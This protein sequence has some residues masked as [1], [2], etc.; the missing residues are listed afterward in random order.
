MTFIEPVNHKE[1]LD[2]A[3]KQI[4]KLE[5]DLIVARLETEEQRLLAEEYVAFVSWAQ[6][7]G[8]YTVNSAHG[9]FKEF[10]TRKVPL[11]VAVE[12]AV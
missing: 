9:R 6:Q 12:K 4:E 2:E 5:K 10:Y 11:A 3:L 1:L 7:L 8:Y